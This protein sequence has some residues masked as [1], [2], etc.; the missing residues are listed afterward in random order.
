MKK[1]MT[2]GI[3]VVCLLICLIPIPL[4]KKDGGSVEYK[5]LFY[6]VTKYHQ[7]VLNPETDSEEGDI[8]ESGFIKGWGIKI[9]GVEIFNNT[10]YVPD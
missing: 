5:A 10:Q 4:R 6:S 1:K 2:V 7:I 9:L 3:I 8:V